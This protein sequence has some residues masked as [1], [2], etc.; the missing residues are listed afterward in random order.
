MSQF[1][2]DPEDSGTGLVP[3]FT[4]AEATRALRLSP[5]SVMR[6]IQADRL[7]CVRLGRT[8]RIRA[9]DLRSLIETR[10]DELSPSLSKS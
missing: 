6:L 3:L 2:T 7:P 1:V 5:R 8:V 9:D 10:E 4:I